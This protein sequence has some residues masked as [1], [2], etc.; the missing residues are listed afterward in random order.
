[1][2]SL[3]GPNTKNASKGMPGVFGMGDTG[4]QGYKQ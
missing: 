1:M 3:D 4:G 2:N